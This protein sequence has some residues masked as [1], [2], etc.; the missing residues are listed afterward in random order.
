LQLN[1]QRSRSCAIK[2]AMERNWQPKIMEKHATL[3]SWI[4]IAYDKTFATL[5]SR[6]TSR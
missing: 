4:N 5:H 6:M 3:K 1:Q 2:T